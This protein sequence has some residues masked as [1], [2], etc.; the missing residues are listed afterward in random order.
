MATRE[1]VKIKNGW[2]IISSAENEAS[3]RYPSKI[4]A[5]QQIDAWEK[6]EAEAILC[7]AEFRATRVE[8]AKA[9]CE[10]RKSRVNNQLRF[11]F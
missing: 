6:A 7:R 1:I 11:N 9:Y 5:Q 10:S 8:A 4:K 2:T 3:Y